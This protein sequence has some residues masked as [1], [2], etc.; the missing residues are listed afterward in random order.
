MGSENYEVTQV[1]GGKIIKSWTRG[2][3]FEQEARAQLERLARLPFVH[4]HL[5][6]MPDVHAGKGS[7]VGTVIATKKVI[8]P[9]TVG[10]DIGCG[11]VA[12]KTDLK[13]S[14]LPDNL[15][16]MRS[17]IE[18]AVPH[19][20]PGDVGAWSDMPSLNG[21][22]GTPFLAAIN[23]PWYYELTNKYPQMDSKYLFRQF[24][25]LGTGNHFVEVC[26]EEECGNCDGYGFIHYSDDTTEDCLQCDGGAAINPAVW[27]M[28]HSGSRGPGNRIGTFFIEK[29][30]EEMLKWHIQLPDQDLSYLPEGSVYYDDYVDAVMW[31]QKYAKASRE[32]MLTNTLFA[33][34]RVLGRMVT[35][36]NDTAVN[37]HHNYVEM[38][39]HFG[40]NVWVTRKGAVRARK[41]ELGIIPGSMN[42]GSFIVR[43]KGNAESFQ[44]CSHGAGRSMSRSEARRRFTLKDVIEQTAGNECR[45]DEGIIDEL[46]LAYKDIGAVMNA[47][48]D[49]VEIVTRLRAVICVKG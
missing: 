6:V 22:D 48:S 32:L 35:T 42:T 39:N 25:T 33:M 15:K 20:G 14:D 38:E 3:E 12:V 11:M 1:E 30:K 40:D 34:A 49:L 7:T 41:G 27:V 16:D 46:P 28:L 19:G 26:L 10:V 37:C 31:A 4:R 36:Y 23:A 47:Q 13:A 18:E 8:I 44:S 45:K 29:A 5:A 2:V 43:G 9:A 24:G 17:A 21:I